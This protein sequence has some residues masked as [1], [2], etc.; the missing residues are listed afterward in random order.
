[1]RIPKTFFTVLP[2]S[3]FLPIACLQQKTDIHYEGTF[4]D[5]NGTS[6]QY[7]RQSDEDAVLYRVQ[8]QDCGD[9]SLSDLALES[10][11]GETASVTFTLHNLGY[12]TPMRLLLVKEGMDWMVDDFIFLGEPVLDWKAA[13]L[14][15]LKND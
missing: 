6:F 7:T 14:E 9:F 11:S 10:L 15:Y 2:A 3:F 4:L 13:M 8:G 5:E 1:M 12:E